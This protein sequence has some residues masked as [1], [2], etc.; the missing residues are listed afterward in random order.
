MKRDR[1]HGCGDTAGGIIVRMSALSIAVVGTDTGVGKTWVAGLLVQG[2]R[3]LGRAV[4]VHKPVACGGWRENQA[5]DGRFWSTLVGDGQPPHSVCPRQYPEPCSPHLAAR[6][7]GAVPVLADYVLDLERARPRNGAD[8]VV[9]GV[10]GLLVPL[11]ADRETVADLLL[12]AGLPLL[13]VTR[14][15]LGTLNHTALTVEVARSRGL[16]VLGL[17]INEPEPVIDSLATRSVAEELSA[18]T[19]VPVLA[20]LRHGEASP[21]CAQILAQ[22]VKQAGGGTGNGER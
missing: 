3:H 12:L 1:G 4:W 22:A 2:L 17:V 8:F 21:A 16:D 19:G 15:Q 6:A 11:T 14:P 5:E 10:G 20:H 18:C 13:L 9:E 7:A